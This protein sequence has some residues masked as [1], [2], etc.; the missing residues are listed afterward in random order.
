[1]LKVIA[2]ECGG[3]FGGK[4]PN[5]NPLNPMAAILSK[6]SGLPVK[7]VMSRKETFESTCPAG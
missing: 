2:M 7:M 6:K 4:G 3:G 5:T 1:M